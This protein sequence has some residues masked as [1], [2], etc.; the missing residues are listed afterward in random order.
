MN[1]FPLIN[2][3]LSAFS[4]LKHL[5]N[6]DRPFFSFPIATEQRT[7]CHLRGPVCLEWLT[8]CLLR[9]SAGACYILG[10]RVALEWEPPKAPGLSADIKMDEMATVMNA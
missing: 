1:A 6:L 5:T 7:V 4:K 9:V 10:A 8:V 2:K 3:S